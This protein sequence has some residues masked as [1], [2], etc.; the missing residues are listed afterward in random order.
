MTDNHSIKVDFS[1]NIEIDHPK[2]IHG[3]TLLFHSLTSKFFACSACRDREEC[4]ILIPYEKRNEKKSKKIIE[5]NEREYK[6][7]IEHIQTLQKNRRKFIKQS[8]M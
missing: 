8:E 1:G 3:P 7:F 4:D 5:Q 2:C 6:R